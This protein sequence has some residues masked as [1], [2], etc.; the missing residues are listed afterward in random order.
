MGRKKQ[1]YNKQ[2]DD[3]KYKYVNQFN[4]D[5]LD[6]WC[7]ELKAQGKPE[8]TIYQYRRNVML[9]YIWIYDNL[10]NRPVWQLKKKQFRNYILYLQSLDLSPARILTIKSSVS[11]MLTFAEDDDDYEEVEQNYMGKIK[12]MKKTESREIVFLTDEQIEILYNRLKDAKKYQE[13]L[14]L[15]LLY[16]TG[17]RKNEIYSLER[18]YI[19]VEQ[20]VTT[21]KV[22]GKRGKKFPL[23]YHE[24]TI[25]AYQLYMGTRTDDSDILW[26]DKNGEKISIDKLYNT[27]KRWNRLLE[28]ETGEYLDF[29]V[30][31]FRHAFATNMQDGTHYV[32]RELGY[33]LS[34]NEIQV[35]LNHD[36]PETTQ[37]YIK[38]NDEEV[39]ARAF[40]WN[41]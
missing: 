41:K 3:E 25:E 8:S 4:K 26:L 23:Y 13:L 38:K 24:R 9:F 40:K 35:I 20:H 1:V 36:S 29:N 32:C 10:D 31:S 12:G 15:A 5:L 37:S 6:D 27:I 28:M 16:D 33:S 17:A 22:T 11:S 30:H 7:F 19:D 18:D 21:K 2:F 39:V 14:L 34:L